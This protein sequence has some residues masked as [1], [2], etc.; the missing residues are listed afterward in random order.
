MIVFLPLFYE[1]EVKSQLN[2]VATNKYQSEHSVSCVPN[3]ITHLSIHPLY[4]LLPYWVVGELVPISSGLRRSKAGYTSGLPAHCRARITHL[5]ENNRYCY[6]KL[7]GGP[8][9]KLP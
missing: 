7:Q 3:R 4:P 2:S 6:L 9:P 5:I 1:G 8:E